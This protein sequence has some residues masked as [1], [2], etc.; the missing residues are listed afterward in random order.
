MMA[1]LAEFRDDIS[2]AIVT[3]GT[4]LAYTVSSNQGFDTLAHM[5]GALIAFTPH[6]TN[7]GAVTLNVDGLGAKPLRSATGIDLPDGSLI[8]GTPYVAT[9]YNTAG[10]WI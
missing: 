1:R 6:A 9:Y 10:E 8:L 2:G 5:D 7:T 4:A 3:S